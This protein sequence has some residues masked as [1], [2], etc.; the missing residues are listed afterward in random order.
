MYESF[1]SMSMMSGVSKAK[2]LLEFPP[3]YSDWVLLSCHWWKGCY[4]THIEGRPSSLLKHFHEY[5]NI[6][7]KHREIHIR[8]LSPVLGNHGVPVW[9]MPIMINAGNPAMYNIW[10][11]NHVYESHT[12]TQWSHY[13]RFHTA[14]ASFAVKNL[15]K[16]MPGRNCMSVFWGAGAI[17]A[18][19]Q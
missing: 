14:G 2:L 6:T 19:P 7:C 3:T 16:N 1:Q 15:T 18:F 5:R 13:L 12:D 10:S 17:L 8:L 9:Q 11:S 4:Q